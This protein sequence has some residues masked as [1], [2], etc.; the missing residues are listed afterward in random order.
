[1]R[2]KHKQ[3]IL[4]LKLPGTTH[5]QDVRAP[6]VKI[7]V[8]GTPAKRYS[9]CPSQYLDFSSHVNGE[10]SQNRQPHT[11]QCL[12]TINTSAR[13]GRQKSWGS[14]WST[15]LTCLRGR[16]LLGSKK[17]YETVFWLHSNTLQRPRAYQA[18]GKVFCGPLSRSPEVD[19]LSMAIG[20]R[21][22]I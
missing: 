12:L 13:G 11:Q 6:Q 4:M 19:R 2:T 20:C 9:L 16:S 1:M 8:L 21:L 18:A 17:L 7:P 14:P 3:V 10:L 22:R 5:L 15:P